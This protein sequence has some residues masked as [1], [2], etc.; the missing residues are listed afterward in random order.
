MNFIK[1]SDFHFG[2]IFSQLSHPYIN[3]GM[4]HLYV[5]QW[6]QQYGT[7]CKFRIYCIFSSMWISFLKSLDFCLF[8][9]NY[10]IFHNLYGSSKIQLWCSITVFEFHLCTSHEVFQITVCSL[11]IYCIIF[12]GLRLKQYVNFIKFSMFSWHWIGLD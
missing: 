2:F 7:L 3:F 4:W 5:H 1:S 11:V 12:L 8:S 10:L 6:M 9:C